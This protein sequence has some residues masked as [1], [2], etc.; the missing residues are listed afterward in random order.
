MSKSITVISDHFPSPGRPIYV[1]VQ[2][3]VFALVDM[4]VKVNVVAPQSLT[5]ALL[6]G[7][8]ILPRV[9]QA[10]TNQGNSFKVYRPYSISFGTGHKRLSKM[11]NNYNQKNLLRVLNKVRPEILYGH[12]WYNAQRVSGYALNHSLPL[13]VACGEGDNAIED[14]CAELS[15]EDKMRLKEAVKGVIS[16]SSENKRKSIKYG[17]AKEENIIVLP[18]CVDDALFHCSDGLSKRKSLGISSE[19]FVVSFTGAF[20]QRKG[21]KTLSKAIKLLNNP[22]LKSIFMGKPMDFDNETPDCPGIVYMSSTEHEKI[23]ELLNASDLFVLPT[24][25]EGCCNA[26]VEALACGIPV[27]SSNRPFNGDI[28]NDGNSIVVNPESVEEVASAI[29]RLMNDKSLY[30]QKRKY[31]VEHSHE[32]SIVERAKKIYNFICD[33]S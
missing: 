2:Q 23:P 4:G 14:L 19:D 13:F 7:E 27:V 10:I 9:F 16:V 8:K 30:S 3:L 18:N 1:F 26:I 22:N 15:T 32:Y 17:L 31:A 28:L 33:R 21:S 6:R 24:L 11:V 29:S 20:I 25:N 5:H 12:F